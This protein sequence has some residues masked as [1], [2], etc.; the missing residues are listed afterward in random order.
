MKKLTLGV[1]LASFTLPAV[2]ENDFSV[3]LLVGSANQE[4]SIDNYGS[5]EGDDLSL[6]IRG[7]YKLHKNIALEV[8]YQDYGETDSTFVDGWGD[9]INDKVSSKAFNLGV[10]GILPFDNGL[11]LNARIGLSIWDAEIKETDSAFPGETFKADDNGNDPYFGL[12]LQYDIDDQFVVGVE[13]AYTEMDVSL[14][15]ISVEHEVK[16]FALSVGYKF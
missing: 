10:K 14:Y 7:A 16:N 12:G 6:G 11:S 2:A 5:T 8:A 15:G 3:E 4:S 13:F 1:L 9:F